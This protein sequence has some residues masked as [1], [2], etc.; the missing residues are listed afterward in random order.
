MIKFTHGLT[1][2]VTTIRAYLVP[3]EDYVGRCG[4]RQRDTF[5][6][7]MYRCLEPVDVKGGHCARHSGCYSCERGLFPGHSHI[8]KLGG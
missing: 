1:R 8:K 4:A 3:D 2:I 6:T 7:V 5:G